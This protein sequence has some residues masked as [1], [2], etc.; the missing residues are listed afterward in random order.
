MSFQDFSSGRTS[1]FFSA[2][3]DQSGPLQRH[4]SLKNIG[5]LVDTP[6][7]LSP[8]PQS[9]DDV[10]SVLSGDSSVVTSLPAPIVGSFPGKPLTREA[11]FSK[12]SAISRVPSAA[13]N[14]VSNR[15]SH[16]LRGA[17][18]NGK[19][20]RVSGETT[21]VGLEAAKFAAIRSLLRVK[22][23][24]IKGSLH[25]DKLAAGEIEAK[26]S[27]VSMLIGQEEWDGV[28]MIGDAF[29]VRVDPPASFASPLTISSSSRR[30]S[31]M[32]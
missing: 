1:P 29:V 17:K 18:A 11:S 31:T 14:L 27:E 24:E 30:W 19:R 21:I 2:V 12:S 3:D 16:T 9:P 26:F 25:P 22:G 23:S 15:E 4:D 20:I 8:L 5:K 13:S 32:K 10:D 6:L 28:F 7:A